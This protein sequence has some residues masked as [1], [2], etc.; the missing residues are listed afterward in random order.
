M[1]KIHRGVSNSRCDAPCASLKPS[2]RSTAPSRVVQRR[3]IVSNHPVIA[4]P[5][6][7][8]AVA[9]RFFYRQQYVSARHK[10]DA[11]SH[12]ASL[13]GMTEVFFILPFL[14][15]IGNFYT[16][17]TPQS[18]NAA[19]VSLRLG[20]GAALT[21]PRHVIHYRAAASLPKRGAK[22]AEQS[23]HPPK[24]FAAKRCPF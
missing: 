2:P 7:K 4:K 22:G 19:S 23:P 11:D 5:V 3:H 21:C 6:R 24:T 18:A 10:G 15:P 12:V 16:L 17:S 1:E 8:L 14:F 20:H 13:L 9:I